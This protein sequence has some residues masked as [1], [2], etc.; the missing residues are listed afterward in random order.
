MLIVTQ[1]LLYTGLAVMMGVIIVRL[2]PLTITV[3]RS[4]LPLAVVTVVS[5]AALPVLKLILFLNAQYD[6]ATSTKMVL[7]TF[8]VGRSWLVVA[9]LGGALLL[10]SQRSTAVQIVLALAMII[11][12]SW[13]SHA[14]SFNQFTGFMSHTVHTMAVSIWVGVLLVASLFASEQQLG[15]SFLRWFTPIALTALLAVS[16]SGVMLVTIITPA[17]VTAWQI[18]YGQALVIKHALIVPLVVY[19]LINGVLNRSERRS[20]KAWLRAES[21]IMLTIFSATAVLSISSPDTKTEK[22]AALYQ[23]FHAN[24]SAPTLSWTLE[25]TIFLVTTLAFSALLLQSFTKNQSAKLS[26]VLAFAT[27][28]SVYCT[29]MLMVSA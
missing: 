26:L 6:V 2:S 16:V 10:S 20:S 14:S 29:A 27:A 13:S 25:G 23:A 8:E 22:A 19:A 5:C 1:T 7:F 9:L 4:V 12:F 28:C 15:K 3:P 17:Y 11:A 21:V 24:L 18:P